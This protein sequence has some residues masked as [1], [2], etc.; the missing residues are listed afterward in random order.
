MTTKH[1]H[2]FKTGDIVSAHGAK[3][4]IID[5]A[6]ESQAHRPRYP[7]L[8]PSDCAIAVG[9]W[10]GGVIVP[11][12]FGPGEDWKFQGNLNAGKYSVNA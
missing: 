9:K 8:G 6:R 3:F 10:V 4:M 12:Y 2:Q 11:G 1:I 7:A 5:D